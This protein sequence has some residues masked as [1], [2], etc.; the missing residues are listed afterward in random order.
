MYWFITGANRGIGLELV[1][2]VASNPDNTVF[3][4]ARNPSSLEQLKLPNVHV[5]KLESTSVSDALEAKKT[6]ERIAGKLDVVIANAGIANHWKNTLDVDTDALVQHFQVNAVGPVILFQALYPLLLKGNTRKFVTVSTLGGSVTMA[7]DLPL[8]GTV[9]GSSKAAL[10]YL[11]RSIHKEHI[12]EGFIVF[13]IHPGVVDTDMG[14]GAAEFLSQWKFI[15]T[16]ESAEGML[17][18]IDSATVEQS[19]HFLSYDGSELPW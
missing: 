12:N 10:N 4:G 11:T 9:Y 19:G 18:V 2:I 13:P 17:K 5:V 3:A 14:Q 7:A 8:P 1:K 6:V 16:K 15:T